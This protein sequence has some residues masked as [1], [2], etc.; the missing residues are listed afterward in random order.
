MKKMKKQNKENVKWQW[1]FHG[2]RNVKNVC[3]IYA[4]GFDHRLHGVNGTLYGKG[5]YFAAQAKMSN[6]YTSPSL[7]N[8]NQCLQFMFIAR[9]ALGRMAVGS[10]EY[11][12]PPLLDPLQPKLGLYNT[13]VDNLQDPIIYVTFDNNQSYPEYLIEYFIR[14]DRLHNH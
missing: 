9:V 11:Q 6:V 7:D 14:S 13:C 12:R 3:S 2:T 5:S 10:G 4:L 8:H 1:V